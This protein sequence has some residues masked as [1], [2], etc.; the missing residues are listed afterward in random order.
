MEILQKSADRHSPLRIIRGPDGPYPT[1]TIDKV[2]D[3][4][5]IP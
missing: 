1:K 3:D 5:S 2:I 4:N